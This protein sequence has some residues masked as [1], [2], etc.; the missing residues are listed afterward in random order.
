MLA[1][2]P[3]DD[4]DWLLIVDDDVVLPRGFL[5]LFLVLRRAP[6]PAGRPARPRLRLAR[7]LAGHA[8]APRARRPA[9]ALRR[10]RPGDRDPRRRVRRAAARCPTSRWAGAWTRTGR[11]P[12][13]PPASSSASSTPRRSGTCAPWPSTTRAA[14]AIAEAEALP[15]RP[16]LRHPR[17][18]GPGPRRLALMRVAVVAEYYPRAADPVLGVWAHRQ[19][20]AARDA[21]A[22]VRVLV[23]HRPVPSRAALRSRDPRGAAS[24]RCASRCATSSTGCAVD[25]VPV[26]RAAAAALLRLAGARGRRRRSRSPCAR[27]GGV[28]V[29]PRPRALRR[30]GRRRGAARAAGR[31]RRRVRPRRR[32][33]RR[34][35][36]VG[37]RQPPRC[38]RACTPRAWCSPTRARSPSAPARWARGATRVVHLG[39]DLPPPAEHGDG[40]LVTVGHLVARKR[41]AD[42][43]RALWL[44]RDAAARCAGTWSATAPS[45]SRCERL[46]GELGL[47]GR[48]RFHGALP[49][50]EARRRR[51]ARR[52]VF[53]LP[54][55]DEAFGVAYIEAMAG[56]VPA[57]GCRGEPGPEEIAAAG[58]GI[59]LVPRPATPRRWPA[60][61]PRPA[62]RRPTAARARRRGAGHGASARSRGSGAGGRRSPPTGTRCDEA[63]PVRDQPRAGRSALGAFAA[64][65]EAEDVVFALVGGGTRHGGADRRRTSCPSPSCG[66]AQRAVGRLAASGRFRAVVAGLSGRVALPAAYLGARAGRVPFVLWATIWRHPRTAAHALSYLPLRHIYRHADAIATYGPHVSA[67]VRAKGAARAGDRGAAER[68]RRVLVRARH[69]APP[70]AVPGPLRRPAGGGEGRRRAPP[71]LAR[72]RPRNGRRARRWPATARCASRA[73]AGATPPARCRRERAAR[74][75]RRLGRRGRSRRSR[76]ATS[77]SRGGWWPTKR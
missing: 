63:G 30:A 65:H 72:R 23:L 11:R 46:A 45:A 41:H 22:D 59:R 3:P 27:C 2:H 47:D 16:P 13:R 24:R 55:V 28:P 14:A 74:P 21:G 7:R 69:A 62:R 56:G 33:A 51:A 34:R 76:R 12:R 44:L 49:P 77:S 36:G 61:A 6:R 25:Y 70:G 15:R 42:V 43:L 31:A 37:R 52:G 8:P 50:A 38:A 67:Y 32:R 18:G 35:A 20:L 19:A 53:V 54:S 58:G 10:D 66:L 60:R 39:A 17:R 75:L 48:V 57:I 64:L 5:D 26:R 68:R 73:R 71:R 40:P 9:H 1:A 29:R 4:A